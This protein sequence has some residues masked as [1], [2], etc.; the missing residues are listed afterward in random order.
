M[1]QL[2]LLLPCLMDASLRVFFLISGTLL[3]HCLLF[4][5][6]LQPW[7]CVRVES[8]KQS[9]FAEDITNQALSWSGSVVARFASGSPLKLLKKLLTPVAL[10]IPTAGKVISKGKGKTTNITSAHR[11]SG[12]GCQSCHLIM[13][14]AATCFQLAASLLHL[15]WT[16]KLDA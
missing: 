11:A 10:T 3:F 6:V 13:A 8:L 2:V 9:N 15:V 5:K 1:Q 14:N 12:H 4:A 7:L 16:Q